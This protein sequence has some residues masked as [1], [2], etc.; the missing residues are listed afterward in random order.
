MCLI[1]GN[2]GGVDDLDNSLILYYLILIYYIFF[3]KLQKIN[4]IFIFFVF[5]P[6][7]C[8]TTSGCV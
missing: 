7:L 2:G 3:F 5:S 6:G 1:A 8:G 4:K